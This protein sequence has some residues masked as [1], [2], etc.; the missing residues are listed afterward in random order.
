MD[1]IDLSICRIIITFFVRLTL[2]RQSFNDP[3][4]PFSKLSVNRNY[5]ASFTSYFRSFAHRMLHSNVKYSQLPERIS[6][7]C[8]NCCIGL[9]I[10]ITNKIVLFITILTV[11]T[12]KSRRVYIDLQNTAERVTDIND[13]NN[14]T[15]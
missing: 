4:P 7:N 9:S 8:N 11:D 2:V 12:V 3:L 5:S 14:F 6:I 15:M 10:D 13:V 1:L